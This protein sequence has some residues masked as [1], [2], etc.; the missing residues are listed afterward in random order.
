MAIVA[1]L[2]LVAVPTFAGLFP[3]LVFRTERPMRIAVMLGWLLVAGVVTVTSRRREDQSDERATRVHD[4]VRTSQRFLFRLFLGVVLGERSKIP[5]G[6]LRWVYLPN[7]SGLLVPTYPRLIVDPADPHVFE[8]GQ[9]ATGSAF[10]ARKPVVAVGDA[11]SSNEYRLSTAQ[12]TF[13]AKGQVVAAVPIRRLDDDV[14]G[15][16]TVYSE[17]NDGF[18]ASPEGVVQK[19]GLRVLMDLAD[20]IGAAFGEGGLEWLT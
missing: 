11:V 14:V 19:D 9:G 20:E 18:F 2:V 10:E 12:Q 8:V 16:L 3:G 5:D 15:A 17:T 13:Y 4:G 7:G 6:Y 1:A